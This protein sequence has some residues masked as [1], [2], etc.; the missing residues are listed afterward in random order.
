MLAFLIRPPVLG[1]IFYPCCFFSFARFSPRSLDPSTDRRET[2][3]HDRKLVRLDKFSAKIRGALT[4]K[5]WGVKNMQNFG[6]FWTTSDFDRKYLRNGARYRKSERCDLERFLPHFTKKVRWTLVH[7]L[8]RNPCEFGPN[9]MYFLADYI[10]AHRGCCALKFLHALEI[11]Q[12]LI[13][14]TQ[15]GMGSPKTF[16]RENL[17]FGLKF[18]VLATITSGLVGVSSQPDDVNFGPQTKTL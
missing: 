12:A 10:W 13:A 6:Q 1:L 8:Q 7:Y 5:K 17:K 3:P 16:D 18:S 11:D 9:K 2:L 4:P 14:H 15:M